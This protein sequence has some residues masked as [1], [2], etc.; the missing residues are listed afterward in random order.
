MQRLRRL[1]MTETIRRMV[2]EVE[3][4][5]DDLITPVFVTEGF[6]VKSNTSAMPDFYTYSLDRLTEA[7]DELSTLGLKQL[8]LFG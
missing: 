2:R 3:L 6:N 4:Q 5:L 7:L 8:I 1:R